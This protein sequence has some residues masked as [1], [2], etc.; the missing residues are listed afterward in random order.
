[1]MMALSSDFLRHHQGGT[2]PMPI[3]EQI[4]IGRCTS[5]IKAILLTLL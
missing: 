2:I 3:I 4:E 1:M 5:E